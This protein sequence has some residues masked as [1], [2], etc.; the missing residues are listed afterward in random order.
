MALNDI[1][2]IVIVI[3]ENRSFDHVVGYLSL[4]DTNVPIPVNGLH[5]DPAWIA[6]YAND[7]PNGHQ[8]DPFRLGPNVQ[9][10]DDPP[11]DW[12]SINRQIT[13]PPHSGLPGTMGGFV[14]SYAQS[15]PHDQRLVMG[16]YDAA[17]VPVFD[18]FAR[19][20]VI[21][22]NWFSP[23]PT[24]TQPNR[25]MAMAGMS[26]LKDNA[27]LKLPDQ[28][29]VYD[30]LGR[31]NISWCHY[32]WAGFPFF[33]L[34]PRWAP[35]MVLSLDG[36]FNDGIFRRYENFHDQWTSNAPMPSVIFIEPKYTD[37]KISLAA[38]NDDHPPTGVAKGQDLLRQIYQTLIS[39]PARWA[40]TLMIVT[41]DEHGGFFD[42]VPPLPITDTAGGYQ[43]LTTGP[44][45]PAFV[46]SSHVAPGTVFSN[47]LDH[48]SILRMLAERF[49]PGK[50]YSAEVETRQQQ[51]LDPLSA[52]LPVAPPAQLRIPTMSDNVHAFV[53]VMAGAVPV[54]PVGPAAPKDT[55]TA[56]AFDAVAHQLALRRPDVLTGPHGQVIADYVSKT[57]ASGGTTMQPLFMIAPVSAEPLKANADAMNKGK[58]AK[59]KRPRGRRTQKR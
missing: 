59:P 21:C 56:Q 49:T 55:E 37:D 18:F 38:P 14:K 34:M 52:V 46:V 41:Y 22:D 6:K 27:T 3:L 16:Y 36:P 40:N 42:H 15:H 9:R 31:N 35:T 58:A 4:L 32:Q 43:F 44:R 23:L 51:Q 50:P 26:Q 24:G 20:F 39:N 1:E 28:E 47:K 10:V 11:H 7:D 5:G 48:T 13:T 53:Q 2:T 33:F 30:W 29:L 12:S 25:L 19:N 8:I 17:A 54:S 57:T 45:V